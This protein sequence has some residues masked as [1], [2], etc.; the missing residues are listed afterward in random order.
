MPL[1]RYFYQRRTQDLFSRVRFPPP[2][3]F[4]R[5]TL[6]T[7]RHFYSLNLKPNICAYNK[8]AT[9][10]H[11]T[12]KGNCVY[13]YSNCAGSW[14]GSVSACRRFL[15]LDSVQMSL[16]YLTTKNSIK[17]SFSMKSTLSLLLTRKFWQAL[18][19]KHSHTHISKMLINRRRKK[20]YFHK[21]EKL[22][23]HTYI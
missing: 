2:S 8:P 20:T 3:L 1:K 6:Y 9:G 21:F 11:K 15:T 14:N 23:A 12:E 4:K 10:N 17:K 13:R 5:P 16:I 19:L 7:S 18:S 22:R